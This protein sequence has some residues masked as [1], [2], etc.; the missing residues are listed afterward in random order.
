MAKLFSMFLVLIALQACLILY[1]GQDAESTQIW[2]FITNLNQWNTLDFVLALVG[3]S[4]GIGLIGVVA[5]SV[6]AFKT[7]FLIFAPAIAGF[8]TMGV[9]FSNFAKFLT[10]QL[11]GIL[12]PACPLPC[13]PVSFIVALIVGPIALYYV[14]TI[15]DWWRGKDF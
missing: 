4:V 14:W 13:A 3:I 7:D 9:I 8:I 15:L 12:S 11:I 2:S 1:T 10:D 5:A 6:F